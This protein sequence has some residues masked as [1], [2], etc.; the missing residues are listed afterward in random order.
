M[1]TRKRVIYSGQVQGVGFRYTAQRLAGRFPVAGYV[2]NLPDGTVELVAE[3]EADWV[4]AFL[5]AVTERMSEY[6]LKTT[7]TDTS[8]G[9]YRGFEIRR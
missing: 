5:E 8:P 1:T 3:G 9:N 4:E 7:V 2:R 6:I